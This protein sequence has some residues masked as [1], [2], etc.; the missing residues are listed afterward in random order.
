MGAT[1]GA[2]RMRSAPNAPE[3]AK[4]PSGMQTCRTYRME[5]SIAEDD[6]R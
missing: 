1:C 4:R 6:V 2:S 3:L 5:T